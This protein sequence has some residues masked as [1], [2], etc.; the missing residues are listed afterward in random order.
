MVLSLSRRT[1]L[2]SSM[3]AAG[4]VAL[5]A[6]GAAATAVDAETPRA[7]GAP[8]EGVAAEVVG[9]AKGEFTRGLGIYPGAPG[10]VY[11]PTMR[12]DATTYRN[13]ALR[14][15]AKHSSS[16]DY[17]LTAQLGT[18]GIKDTR[19]PRWVSVATSVDGVLTKPDREIVLD[20]FPPIGVKLEGA[21]VW[22][23][24]ELGGYD[25][26]PSV[27]KLR[28]FVALPEWVAAKDLRFSV[29]AS[30]DG[31]AWEEVG[32]AKAEA[33]T[34]VENYPPDL[35]KGM[36][37]TYPWVTLSRVCASRFYRVTCE[38]LNHPVGE[39]ILWMVG[40]VEFYRAGARVEIGGPY[41]F[42]SAWMSAG[43]AEEWVS[44]DLGARCAIDRV[45]LHWIARAA[46][47]SVQISDDE[48]KWTDV[49]RLGGAISKEGLE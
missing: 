6:L 25:V 27:D 14:R 49:R 31:R 42:T 13:L 39:G 46:E 30:D 33:E 11:S 47:G 17:N 26:A 36:W 9:G 19:M 18:D 24:V 20:H 35:T 41:D 38:R 23:Q 28:V 29:E 44:V 8:V 2:K 15:A 4:E 48:V 43:S 21:K 37:L 34:A 10:D 1:F 7:A 32:S 5:P 40:Q 16:Y 22:V 45:S 12:L 3:I